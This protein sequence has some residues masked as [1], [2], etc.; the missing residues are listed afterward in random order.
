MQCALSRDVI[1]YYLSACGGSACQARAKLGACC[2]ER[3]SG[4]RERRGWNGVKGRWNGIIVG[5]YDAVVIEVC[6]GFGA[7]VNLGVVDFQGPSGRN[8]SAQC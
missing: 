7:R 1:D 3:G 2:G 4:G 8:A 5:S 6:T